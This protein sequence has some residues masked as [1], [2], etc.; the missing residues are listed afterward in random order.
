MNIQPKESVAVVSGA[1]LASRF[2]NVRRFSESLAE[3]LS[4]EDCGIQSMPDASPTKW[5]L[6]HTTWFFETFLQQQLDTTTPFD[7]RFP[8][9]FN[10]YYN[11]LGKQFSRP[12]RGVLSRPSL[13]EV[14]EYRRHVDRLVIDYLEQQESVTPSVGNIV[15]IGL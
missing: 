1:A 7:E 15:E 10:S 13:D 12:Q 9:I 5:H 11:S 8:K 3:P 6:G 4:A 2:R 14:I